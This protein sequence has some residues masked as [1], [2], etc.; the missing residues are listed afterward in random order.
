MTVSFIR[1]M[2]LG[3]SGVKN[4]RKTKSWSEEVWELYERV[5]GQQRPEFF[6]T[7]KPPAS[8]RINAS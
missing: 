7:G 3:G 6:R 4:L 5:T 2:V 1:S 8:G